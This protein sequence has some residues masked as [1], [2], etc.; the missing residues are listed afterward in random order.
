MRIFLILVL[1]LSLFGL[2][3]CE[4]ERDNLVRM[5]INHFT[6]NCVGV[7]PQ[8]CLL[9]QQGNQI[10]TDD[11]SL[12]YSSIAGFDY[13][14]GFTYDLWVEVKKVKNPPADASS[15]TY[16]LLEIIAKEPK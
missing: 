9:V 1:N 15:L 13:E 12:F 7:A 14:S 10:G 8:P 16:K 4:K 5:R 11:W 2:F 3:S 6:Q